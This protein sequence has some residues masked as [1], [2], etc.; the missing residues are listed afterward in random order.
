MEYVGF[1]NL[2]SIQFFDNNHHEDER[3]ED[4]DICEIND[5]QDP[6]MDKLEP[7]GS[8]QTKD[9]DIPKIHKD[10]QDENIY[11]LEASEYGGNETNMEC[12]VESKTLDIYPNIPRITDGNRKGVIIKTPVILAQLV[13]PLNISSYIN[14]P[15][16]ASG[17]KDIKQRLTLQECILL[18]PADVLFIKGFATKSVEYFM[19]DCSRDDKTCGKVNHYTVN[20]PFECSTAVS[21]FTEPLGPIMST[22]EILQHGEKD[23]FEFNQ[24]NESFYNEKPFCKL[25]SSKIT[26][27]NKCLDSDKSEK[28]FTH[29]HENMAIELEIEV[30]QNQPVAIPPF[31][32]KDTTD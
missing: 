23:L 21:F 3:N 27:Y 7:L 15:Q 32:G 29:I 26:E 19:V 24:I 2:G 25:L 12:R 30:L 4:V 9:I 1:V 20:I 31:I 18:Q 5:N 28:K 17:I 10:D 14:L 13:V 16:E 6:D 8:E 22:K 11:N